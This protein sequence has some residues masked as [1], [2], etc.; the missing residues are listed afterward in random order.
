M[1]TNAPLIHHTVD[2]LRAWRASLPGDVVLVPTMGNLHAGHQAL[3]QHGK[4]LGQH[5]V[6]SIFVNPSQFG[7]N[8]DYARYPRTLEAD[9]EA[10]HHAGADA[11]FMPDVDTLYP[12]GLEATHRFQVLPPETLTNRYCGA[13]RPGHFNGVCAVVL[14]LLHIVQPHIALFGQKDAQQLAI[15]RAM[16]KDWHLPVK[17][18]AHPVVRSP[19]GLALSSRNQYLKT[20]E[21]LETALALFETMK[22]V[23]TAFHVLKGKALPVDKTFELAWKGIQSQYPL[24]H[25][26]VWDYQAAVED[27]TFAP[28]DTLTAQSRL[29]VAAR[30]GDVRLIDTLHI[31]EVLA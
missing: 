23:A 27:D 30:L 6:V 8:E 18:A 4:T 17:L 10:C 14:G 2:T 3:I 5:V 11:L 28:Q 12:H 20:P 7:P 21:E 22:G 9:V 19:E 31:N 13:H 26:L 24:G 25:E 1:Y 15:L 16:V 29:L